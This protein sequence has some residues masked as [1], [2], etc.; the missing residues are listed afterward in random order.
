MGVSEGGYLDPKKVLKL[1][2]DGDKNPGA[3]AGHEDRIRDV[4]HNRPKPEKP[5]PD[6]EDADEE[7]EVD[8]GNEAHFLAIPIG[9]TFVEGRG[10]HHGD[11]RWGERKGREGGRD[12]RMSRWR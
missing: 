6:L 1:G 9:E 2:D 5:Q 7:S 12:R 10:G 8:G 11:E 3:V 4:V